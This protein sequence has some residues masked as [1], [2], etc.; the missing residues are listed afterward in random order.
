MGKLVVVSGPS[1]VG[2]DTAVRELLS[3]DPSFSLAVS[4]TTRKPR[5]GEIDG[6]DYHFVDE[7]EFEEMVIGG[8]FLEHAVYNG[9]RYGTSRIAVHDGLAKG[10]VVLVIEVCGAAQVR[11]LFKG[12]VCTVFIFA[13]P[14]VLRARLLARGKE[15]F[16]GIEQRLEIAK[17][18]IRRAAEFDFSIESRED[19]SPRD[20]ARMILSVVGAGRS[21]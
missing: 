17:G 12:G 7:L 4:H 6:E 8:A 16:L 1:G 5:E 21:A 18:E 13:L 14:D 9:F 10:N 19:T 20:I 11:S 15:S 2:K 3:M